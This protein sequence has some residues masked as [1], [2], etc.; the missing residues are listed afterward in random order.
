MWGLHTFMPT[1]KEAWL[2][3]F[4]FGTSYNTN[5]LYFIKKF[6]FYN[7]WEVKKCQVYVTIV[8]MKD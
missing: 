4:F 6:Y 8:S 3:S 2:S 5:A 1:L 7:I